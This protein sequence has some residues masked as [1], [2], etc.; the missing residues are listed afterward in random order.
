MNPD[1]NVEILRNGDEAWG[2]FAP[3]F[4]ELMDA[5]RRDLGEDLLSGLIRASDGTDTLSPDE[6][7]AQA[8]L[9]LV[10]GHETTANLIGN[11]TLALLRHP[12]ELQK[13]RDDPSLVRGAIEELLRFEGPVTA[14]IRVALEEITIGAAR[15]PP[16]HDV[17]IAIGAANRDPR[18][19][20]DPDRLDV[21]RRYVKHLAFSGGAHFC[22]GAPLARLEAEIALTALLKRFPRIECAAE[23]PQWRETIT[24][25]G[26]TRLPLAV[27][28]P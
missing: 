22:L 10:A 20:P 18:Q 6:V 11:G 24:L 4:K 16:G 25:R 21:T 9:L 15:V 2:E 1:E 14:V 28:S 17:L 12:D 23:T 19:F 7:L 13:L 3:Y 26:L 27:R 8:T 5:R